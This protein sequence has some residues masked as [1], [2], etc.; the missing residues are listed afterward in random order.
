MNFLTSGH[1]GSENTD[2][3]EKRRVERIMSQ[4]FLFAIAPKKR[5]RTDY[6][7][8][9]KRVRK[10]QAELRGIRVGGAGRAYVPLAAVP[11]LCKAYDAAEGQGT[12]RLTQHSARLVQMAWQIW[13][14]LAT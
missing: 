5:K 11:D 12:A 13:A 4:T 7:V 14:T 8:W 10:E 9:D 3:Q 1:S 2:K 6:A